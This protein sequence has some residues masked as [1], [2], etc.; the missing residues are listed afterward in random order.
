MPYH[1]SHERQ[2]RIVQMAVEGCSIRA[3]GRMTGTHRDTVM[4][5][6]V[7]V[8][9]HC[10]EL[11]RRH[12]RGLRCPYIQVDE[13][14]CFCARK[15]RWVTGAE[16]EAG[17]G[18]TY[19][20]VALDMD[21]KLVPAFLTGK[22]DET[23]CLAFLRDL[24]DRVEGA[25][26]ITTDGWRAYPA[27]VRATFAGRC[28]YGQSRKNFTVPLEDERRY[29]PPSMRSMQ[30]LGFWNTPKYAYITTSHVERQNLTMRMQMRRFTRLTNGFSRKPANLRAAVALHFAWYNFVRPHS[31]HGLTPAQA[32]GLCASPRPIEWLLPRWG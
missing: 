17:Y 20:F 21:S 29:S 5:H 7:R 1:I 28:R 25:V 15:Q 31:A 8:G 26:Q 12:T 11:H 23:H 16:Y 19:T 9:E 14:W 2:R 30:K 6:L 18:D 32:A 27:A 4:R 24:A 13:T 10:Q 22:R 3:I